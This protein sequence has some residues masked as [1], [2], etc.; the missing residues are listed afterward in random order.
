MTSELP[1]NKTLIR[2]IMSVC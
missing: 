1:F 2:S